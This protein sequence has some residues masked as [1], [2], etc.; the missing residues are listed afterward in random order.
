MQEEKSTKPE[1]GPSRR[2]WFAL[3]GSFAVAAILCL[4]V[5]VISLVSTESPALPFATNGQITES[6]PEQEHPETIANSQDDSST[7]SLIPQAGGRSAGDPYMPELG[8]TGYDV[9]HYTLQL[10]LNPA[11]EYLEG[12]TTVKAISTVP[13]LSEISLDFIGYEIGV[14]TVDGLAVDFERQ[15]NK[16]VVK[17]PQNVPEQ[18]SFSIV[19]AYRGNPPSESSV[20]LRSMDHLGLHY[21]SDNNLFAISEPDGAR[22]WFPS[23]DHLRDKATFR[24]ELVVP[25]GLTAVANGNLQ[26]TRA[27]VLPNGEAGDL[28][29][30]EHDFPMAPYLAVIAAGDYERIEDRSPGGVPL[31][32][33][34]QSDNREKALEAAN[35]VSKAIDWI[36][37]LFGPY[38][39]DTFGFVTAPVT[40]RS[41]ET[42]TMVLL[43]NDLIGKRTAVHELAHMWFGDWVGLDSWSE[44]WRKEGFATYVQIMWETRDDPEELDIQMA[45][46]RSVVEGNDKDYPINNPPPEYLFELNVY[47]EGALAVHALRREIG[48][49]AF[50]E[51][52]RRYID[53]YGG[54]TASDAD[55]QSVMEEAAGRPLDAFFSSLFPAE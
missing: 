48:D 39:F 55:F 9:L 13:G 16:L 6:I 14:V 28:F 7:I 24:F 34:V 10:V 53:R 18:G 44:M 47:F 51:G 27:S 49:Q 25:K 21:P 41:M 33:Y 19:I 11:T 52:V 45:T 43:S 42:Q 8:N 50:F 37:E 40:G 1:S 35:E 26:E 5:V 32:Y 38:P 29:I 12:T 46:M 36:A 22:Y 23:N 2:L 54:K 15:A 20:Y 30:W 3:I 31:R 17:L 4:A